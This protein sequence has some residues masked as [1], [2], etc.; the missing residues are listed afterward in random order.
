MLTLANI[1]LA[2]VTFL[3]IC[4]SLVVVIILAAGTVEIVS[5]VY[6]DLKK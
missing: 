3:A 4:V 5:D 2:F 6:R 1:F